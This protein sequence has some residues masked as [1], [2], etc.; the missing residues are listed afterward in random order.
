MPDPTNPT[1][2]QP[3]PT[4]TPEEVARAEAQLE[5]LRKKIK[6][7]AVLE[8]AAAEEAGVQ[9]MTIELPPQIRKGIAVYEMDDGS[10]AMAPLVD[11][12]GLMDAITLATRLL[13]GARADLIARKTVE[14]QQAQARAPKIL[15]PGR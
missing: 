3:T 4:P 15:V 13:E 6:V 11:G 2:E 1:P 14:A 12:T 10:F 8:Q 9:P 5:E 7:Q